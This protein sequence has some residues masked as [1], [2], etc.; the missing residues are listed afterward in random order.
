M[1]EIVNSNPQNTTGHKGVHTRSTFPLQYHNFDTFRFGEYHP[2]FVMEGVAKDK[3]SFRSAHDLRSYTLGAPL[4]EDISM[5]KDYFSVPM[6][7]I[8]PLNWDKFFSNPVIGQDAPVDCGPSVD[9]FY[10]L[11]STRFD[12]LRQRMTD[13]FAASSTFTAINQLTTAALRFIVLGEY[14][15]SPGSLMNSLGIHSWCYLTYTESY[16]DSGGITRFRRVNFDYLVDKIAAVF[17]SRFLNIQVTDSNGVVRTFY[18]NTDPTRAAQLGLNDLLQYFREDPASAVTS[19]SYVQGSQMSDF[20][21][22]IFAIVPSSNFTFATNTKP[23]N[24]SRLA[25]YQLVVSQFYTNDSIDFIF[26]ANRYRQLMWYYFTEM[27]SNWSGNTQSRNFTLNSLKFDYDAFSAHCLRVVIAWM[28]SFNSTL[29]YTSTAGYV[30]ALSYLS[31]LFSFKRSL[32][33]KDYFTGSRSQPLAV[34][35]VDV[36][37]SGS[38]TVSVIDITKNIQRQRFFNAVN[39][40]GARIEDYYQEIFGSKLAPDYT[41][42]FYLGHTSD[43]I[44]GSEVEN[45]GDIQYQEENSVTSALRSNGS[46]YEFTYSPDRDCILIGLTYFD[47]ARAYTKS[48]DR[49]TMH[50]DRFDWFNPFMQFIGDQKVYE[51]EINPEPALQTTGDSAFSYQN[52]HMEYKQRVNVASGGFVANLPGWA[53]LAD[54]IAND[55]LVIDSDFIRSRSAELDKFYLRLTGHSLSTY[56]HFIVKNI[57]D[58][59]GSRPMAYAPSIL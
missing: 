15:Y 56:Y 52:R 30:C 41:K 29:L 10:V 49:Q 45:T 57:N 7:A 50:L 22:D 53:F 59:T 36:N 39:R 27:L 51:G 3:I 38:N 9:N 21:A 37:V 23:L 14:V 20:K 54:D 55:N 26:D 13:I 32:K 43:V 46:R 28:Q 31:G 33:F 12:A 2:H 6:T 40:V 44:F 8:L 34:G 5:K 11:W 24:V 17:Q 1:S 18:M 25:A 4:M 35:N 42:P 19:V 47:I 16:T 58:C 48:I